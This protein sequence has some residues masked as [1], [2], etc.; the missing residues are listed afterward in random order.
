MFGFFFDVLLFKPES[1][2]HMGPGREVYPRL[3]ESSPQDP[4][5]VPAGFEKRREGAPGIPGLNAM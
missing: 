3:G 4:D 1:Y 2:K 5:S